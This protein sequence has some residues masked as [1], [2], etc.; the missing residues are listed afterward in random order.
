MDNDSTRR[1]RSRRSGSSS[2]T[3]RMGLDPCI[4]PSEFVT[5]KAKQ[6]ND[7]LDIKQAIGCKFI[8]LP[9]G[10]PDLD[11]AETLWKALKQKHQYEDF[12][13]EDN[14]AKC[15]ELVRIYTNEIKQS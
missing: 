7:V 2:H 15:A 9:S 6:W 11:I 14:S 13:P 10:S 4:S 8:F 1:G 3:N 12:L 5:Y